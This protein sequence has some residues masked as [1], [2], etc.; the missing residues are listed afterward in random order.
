MYSIGS[1]AIILDENSKVLLCLRTDKN[2]WNLPGGKV[3]IGESPWAAVI[4]EVKEETGLDVK[5]KRLLGVYSKPEKP[6]IV[7]SFLCQPV[8]GKL[9]LNNEAKDLKYFS[10][11][12]IP[13]N[14]LSK[15]VARI[16]H[17]FTQKDELILMEQYDNGEEVSASKYSIQTL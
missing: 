17:Y 9:T 10:L 11:D 15:H 8:S 6:D 16:K 3:E 14:T 1:F 2:V 4:R 13:E 7:F 5:I 12:E